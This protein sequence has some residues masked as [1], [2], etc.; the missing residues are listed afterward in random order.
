MLAHLRAINLQL[1]LEKPGCDVGPPPLY[2]TA[3]DPQRSRAR[4]RGEENTGIAK[5]Y[6]GQII[7]VPKGP[8]GS[9]LQRVVG[10]LGGYRG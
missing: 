10:W 8:K 1:G 5:G 7:P 3:A 6:E 9:T 2:D 4:R